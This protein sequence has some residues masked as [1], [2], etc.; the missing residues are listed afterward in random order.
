MHTTMS[1][2]D[3]MKK[4]K[5]I[6]RMGSAQQQE[7]KELV[8]RM[9]EDQRMVQMSIQERKE[10][11]ENLMARAAEATKMMNNPPDDTSNQAFMQK[12]QQQLNQVQAG[13]SE[14][15]S[16]L[17]VNSTSTRDSALSNVDQAASMAARLAARMSLEQAARTN[18]AASV[19]KSFEDV[20]QSLRAND[21]HRDQQVEKWE[22][23]LDGL[24][25]N[26]QKH[27]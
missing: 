20:V 26:L 24:D 11:I 9:N 5:E 3:K 12:V 6:E 2:A 22:A 18:S 16:F 15:N 13:L 14:F 4:I 10:F 21:K 27:S 17:E 25:Q 23:L 7:I 19:T 1:A 8:S